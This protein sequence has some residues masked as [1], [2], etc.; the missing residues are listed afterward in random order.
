M[1]L[2]DGGSPPV[3]DCATKVANL[4]TVEA[5]LTIAD[6]S[7]TPREDY[8]TWSKEDYLLYAKSLHE[9]VG[10]RVL[11]QDLNRQYESGEG[12]HPHR[13]LRRFG[14]YIWQLNESFGVETNYKTL[15]EYR[16]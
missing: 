1:Y 6:L 16:N 9:S 5:Q 15:S 11:Y 13:V 2:V 10:G 8:A 12:P 14:G 3:F 7:N 4:Q